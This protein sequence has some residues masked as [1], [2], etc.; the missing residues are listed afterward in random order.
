M[1]TMIIIILHGNLPLQWLL[2]VWLGHRAIPK[3]TRCVNSWFWS[4]L[5][6]LVFVCFGFFWTLSACFLNVVFV[7]ACVIG[8]TRDCSN[9]RKFLGNFV[10]LVPAEKVPCM[11]RQSILICRP[12]RERPAFFKTFVHLKNQ[13]LFV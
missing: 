4:V 3:V 5:K 13:I 11:Y 9:Y 7:G 12:Q 2:Q 10:V 8:F 1:I 6:S